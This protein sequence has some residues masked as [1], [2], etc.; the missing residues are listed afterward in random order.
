MTDTRVVVIGAP[1]AG[2][3][4]YA[5]ARG[6]REGVE[7]RHTDDL[8]GTL[9]W[10]GV[11]AHVASTWFAEPGPWIVEG[12]AAVRALRKWLRNNREGMPC[13]E[14]VVLEHPWIALTAGQA[15]MAK[16]CA[17]VWREI[18]ADLEQRGVLVVENPT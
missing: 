1:R 2:K 7:V 3:T 4:T 5:D 10:S 12:V 17:K 18:R 16:V 6:Q 13:D 11:S 15:R 14:V 8:I 9:D